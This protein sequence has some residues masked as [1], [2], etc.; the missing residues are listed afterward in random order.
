MLGAS[1]ALTCG[2]AD[3]ANG[4]V[5]AGLGGTG[6]ATPK[7]DMLQTSTSIGSIRYVVRSIDMLRTLAA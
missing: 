7:P 5:A 2:S 4:P 3:R 1:D 6:A